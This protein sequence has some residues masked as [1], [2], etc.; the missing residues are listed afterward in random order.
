MNQDAKS[1][2]FK[3]KKGGWTWKQNVDDICLEYSPDIYHNK[4]IFFCFIQLTFSVIPTWTLISGTANILSFNME[5]ILF[6]F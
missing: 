1:C 2:W 3:T 4:D 6:K 5:W